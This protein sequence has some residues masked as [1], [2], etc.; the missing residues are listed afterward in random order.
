MHIPFKEVLGIFQRNV[1]LI[2]TS[3]QHAL[4]SDSLLDNVYDSLQ[5]LKVDSLS[6]ILRYCC[7]VEKRQFPIHNDTEILAFHV[8]S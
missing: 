7:G 4:I 2:D 8:N 5:Q 6:F 3:K 1:A